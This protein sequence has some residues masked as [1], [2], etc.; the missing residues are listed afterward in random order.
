[1]AE[2]QLLKPGSLAPDFSLPDQNGKIHRLSDFRGKKVVL[3]FYP[4]DNTPGCTKEACGFRDLWSQISKRAVVF[5][6]SVDSVSS[7]KR[8]SEKYN[9][10]F[11]LLSDENK[12]VVKAYK[13]WGTK[14][15][16]GRQ[17]QGTHRVTYLIDES[18]RIA[19]VYDKVKP[20]THPQQVLQDLS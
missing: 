20:E 17:F 10:P 9:L 14:K 7:H 18:G 16:M 4:K 3:Y 11:V 13:V 15:F 5:G 8:F 2:I 1:M 6:V 12:E 19:K